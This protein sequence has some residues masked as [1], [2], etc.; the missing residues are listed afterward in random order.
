MNYIL[1][2]HRGRWQLRYH[3]K[4]EVSEMFWFD[5]IGKYAKEKYELI[6]DLPDAM[7]EDGTAGHILAFE[8]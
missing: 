8:S 5:V 6:K 3:P 7:Y 1:N 4:N 2:K